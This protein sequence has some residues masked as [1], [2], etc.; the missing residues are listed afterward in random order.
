MKKQFITLLS[1][2]S[3]MIMSACS[4]SDNAN[5]SAKITAEDVEEIVETGMFG[6]RSKGAAQSAFKKIGLSIDKIKPDFEYLDEDT[7]KAYR[8]VVYRDNYEGSAV[9]IKKDMSDASEDEF[10]AYVRKIYAQTQEIADDHKVIYGFESKSNPEE[11]NAEWSIDEILA[12]KGIMGFP[13][14]SYD[15]GFKRDGKFM[16]MNV[17]L[18]SA[19]KKYPQRL[20]IHFYGAL[21]KSFDDTMKDAEKALEDPEVQKAIKDAFKKD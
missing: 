1:A 21:Q 14:T 12:Q 4:G 10:K 6:E 11:A 19:N 16:R 17:D 9:F 7:L 13:R 8:G 2:A 3:I 18:L 15:W 20:E 5:N